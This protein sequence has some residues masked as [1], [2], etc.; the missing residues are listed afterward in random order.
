[1]RAKKWISGPWKVFKSK[2][3]CHEFT[4]HVY[5]PSYGAI[6]Y[7]KGHKDSHDDSYWQLTEHEAH[8]ISAAPEAIALLEVAKC[9]NCDGTG[10]ISRA[11]PVPSGRCDDMGWDIPDFQQEVEQCQWCHERAKVLRKAYGEDES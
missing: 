11:V 1:M 8:L 2:Q 6:G 4:H 3:D 10:A 7:A 9:P 5:A